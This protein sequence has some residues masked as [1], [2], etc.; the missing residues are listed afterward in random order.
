M[1]YW[2]THYE[3]LSKKYYK[4]EIED[5]KIGNDGHYWNGAATDHQN[6]AKELRSMMTE[7]IRQQISENRIINLNKQMGI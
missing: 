3:N 2:S 1:T 4:N 7:I 5:I 6:F